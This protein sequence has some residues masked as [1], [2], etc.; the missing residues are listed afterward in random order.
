MRKDPD[1]PGSDDMDVGS[2]ID[3]YK[4]DEVEDENRSPVI[5]QINQSNRVTRA[6]VQKGNFGPA[7]KLSP[8]KPKPTMGVSVHDR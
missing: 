8:T 7:R 1:R 6:G 2:G 4:D 5:M 3:S